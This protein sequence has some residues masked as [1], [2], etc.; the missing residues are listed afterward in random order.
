MCRKSCNFVY[1]TLDIV[2]T[3]GIVTIER[4]E[5]TFVSIAMR[6]R[7]DLTPIT[8]IPVSFG[9]PQLFYDYYLANPTYPL[10]LQ[11]HSGFERLLSPYIFFYHFITWSFTACHSIHPLYIAKLSYIANLVFFTF[12]LDHL[13]L[14][15]FFI[16]NSIQPHLPLMVFISLEQNYCSNQFRFEGFS[17]KYTPATF[18]CNDRWLLC[19]HDDNP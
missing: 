18:A 6:T 16:D 2:W 7:Q 1:I 14:F 9:Q 8:T 5:D 12:P 13:Q 17:C 11:L 10:P 15:L 4:V 3:F 19:M